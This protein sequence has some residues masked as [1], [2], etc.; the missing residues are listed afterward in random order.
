MVAIALCGTLADIERFAVENQWWFEQYPDLP[1]EVPSHDTL[2]RVFARLDTDEFER[3][4]LEYV[5]CL[6]L[7]LQGRTIAIDGKTLRGSHD[8]SC[9]QSCTHMITA[10]AAE[11]STVLGTISTSQ[12]SN[13]IPAVQQLLEV[14]KLKGA[15]MAADAM[16][17]QKI[18]AA[19]IIE[20]EADYVLQLK[21]N[22]PTLCDSVAA[23]F[24]QH[25]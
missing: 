12:K 17:C 3:S 2:G 21:R 7:N 9:Q 5:R 15:V 11:L 18:T 19:M 22:Q 24:E 1:N 25:T 13:E 20:H 8:R 6:K 10:W 16:H 23:I 4:L 14:M